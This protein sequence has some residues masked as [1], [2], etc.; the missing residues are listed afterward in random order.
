MKNEWFESWFDSKYYHIL[1]QNRDNSEAQLFINNLL[2]HLLIQEDATILDLACGKGRHSVY[3]ADKGFDVTGVDLSEES[4]KFARQFEHEKLS[5]F[6][7]DMREPFRFNYFDYIFNFFTSFGY[8]QNDYEHLKTL[9]SIVKGLRPN[10]IFVMD[11]MNVEAIVPK[12]VPAE[13]KELQGIG[14]DITRKVENGYIVKQ[15]AFEDAGQAWKHQE[16]VRAFYRKD[17]EGMFAKAGLKV[18]NVFGD[19]HLS[20]YNPETS[21]RLILIAQKES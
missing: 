17:L 1:Y 15:I 21:K 10:G 13:H 4:I 12:L 16:K 3:L 9:K 2:A 20:D 11:F 5:F 19:Y 7:Q 18:M 14:F 8:F 6:T